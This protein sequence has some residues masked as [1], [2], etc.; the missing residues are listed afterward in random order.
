LAAQ[1]VEEENAEQKEGDAALQK[2][3]QDIYK[4]MSDE[5]RRA[6]DKLFIC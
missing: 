2:L 4:N 3:S 5:T 6:M 1:A